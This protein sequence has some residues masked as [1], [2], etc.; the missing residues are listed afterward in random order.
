MLPECAE[1]LPLPATFQCVKFVAIGAHD[2]VHAAA[3]PQVASDDTEGVNWVCRVWRAVHAV[4]RKRVLDAQR[5]ERDA[6][7]EAPSGRP[8]RAQQIFPEQAGT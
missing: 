6:G 4:R 2:L 5:A 8:A 1:L 3:W 7:S